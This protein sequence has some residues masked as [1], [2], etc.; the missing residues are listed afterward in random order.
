MVYKI[1]AHF[2]QRSNSPAVYVDAWFGQS[3]GTAYNV[4]PQCKGDEANLAFCKLGKEWGHET[5]SHTDDAGI[6][7]TATALGGFRFTSSRCF[8]LN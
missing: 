7:C 4:M 6:G 8:S 3:N 5:C 1:T 2:Q